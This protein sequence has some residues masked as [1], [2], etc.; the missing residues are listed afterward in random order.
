MFLDFL[1][2]FDKAKNRQ[3]GIIFTKNSKGPSYSFFN[4]SYT[5]YKSLL[6]PGVGRI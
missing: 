5:W 6:G 4:V 1:S 3:T 2:L